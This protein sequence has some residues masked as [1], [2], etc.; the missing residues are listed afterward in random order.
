VPSYLDF[1]LLKKV[2]SLE[3]SSL[4]FSAMPTRSEFQDR[5]DVLDM[6]ISIL[7]DH[8][9]NLSKLAD[10][11]DATCNDLSI[12]EEKLTVL[13]QALERLNG[14]NVKNVIGAVGLKGPL[15]TIECKDWLTFRGASQG[16]LLAVFEVVD[17]RFVMSSVSDL[18]IFTYSESLPQVE[19][20]M[21]DR[22]EKS[23]KHDE[24]LETV[25]S[26]SR[27]RVYE[28]F[29]QPKMVKRWLASELGVPEKRV[30]EGRIL[31]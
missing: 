6:I 25:S 21:G 17:E 19:I 22:I 13:D 27:E 4:R 1:A 20:L 3:L 5:I 11:F 15:V 29:L 28:E 10:H 24:D 31:H 23:L 18:F 16:A 12:V 2:G 14:L 26:E 9:E 7:R 30:V 8:E